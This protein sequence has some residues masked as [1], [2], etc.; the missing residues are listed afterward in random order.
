MSVKQRL[1]DD[2]NFNW[3][4]SSFLTKDIEFYHIRLSIPKE[5]FIGVLEI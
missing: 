3:E 2:K 4:K 1:L 5:V